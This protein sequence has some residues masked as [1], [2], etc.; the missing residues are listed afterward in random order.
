MSNPFFKNHG[1]IKLSEI[2]KSLNINIGESYKDKEI[3]DI[4][5]LSSSIDNDITFFH[6]KKYKDVA[7]KTKASFC[8]TTNN[9]K[10]E[11]P[12]NCFA[13]VVENVLVSTSKI[14]SLFYPGAINDD[15]DKTVLDI[16][17]TEFTNKVTF[18]KNVLIGRNVLIGENCKIGH[19]TIIEKN[20]IIG[21]NC[22]LGSNIIIRNALI[23]KLIELNK[24]IITDLF[25]ALLNK[26][27]I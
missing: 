3:H 26:N 27:N 24:V 15:F 6:S 9:L 21:D 17:D 13:L 20:V 8:L 16:N 7:K 25:L 4:K 18:G 12:K 23:S 22:S 1:P 5:D 19:N 14:T 11:L 10:A 2:I